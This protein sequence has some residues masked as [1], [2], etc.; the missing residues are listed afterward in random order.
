MCQLPRL[1][2]LSSLMHIINIEAILF[3][4]TYWSSNITL[5]LWEIF[6]NF[7]FLFVYIFIFILQVLILNIPVSWTVI[8]AEVSK[9][10]AFFQTNKHKLQSIFLPSHRLTTVNNSAKSD[11]I[12][13]S[14]Y[15]WYYLKQPYIFN[16]EP[17]IETLTWF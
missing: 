8:T 15:H 17:P 9:A 14:P 4:E 1:R 7:H 12:I 16:A 3:K 11:C 5:F 6:F 2:W 13:A 10:L